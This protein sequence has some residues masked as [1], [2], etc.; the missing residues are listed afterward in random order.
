MRQWWQVGLST[1]QILTLQAEARTL[2]KVSGAAARKIV[3]D[4]ARSLEGRQRQEAVRLSRLA[5]C[6]QDEMKD[7]G[8]VEN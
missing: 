4:K 3:L 2:C 5:G 7:A 1:Q 6:I 8:R